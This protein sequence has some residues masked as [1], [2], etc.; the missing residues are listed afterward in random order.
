MANFLSLWA[1]TQVKETGHL[2]DSAEWQRRGKTCRTD[3][4]FIPGSALRG[5][6]VD[7]DCSA[8]KANCCNEANS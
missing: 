6:E 3:N 4:S 2:C 8:F 7:K 1:K 5:P